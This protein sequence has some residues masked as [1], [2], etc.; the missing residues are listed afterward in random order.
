MPG[1]RLGGLKAAETN[2]Q[3]HGADFFSRIG[4]RGGK[5]TGVLKGFAANRKLASEAGKLGGRRS[6]RGPKAWQA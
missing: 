3:R 6:R 2:L 4:S 1:T 5:K